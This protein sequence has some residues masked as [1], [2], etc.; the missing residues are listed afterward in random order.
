MSATTSQR[1]PLFFQLS[2][3]CLDI[4]QIGRPVSVHR[5]LCSLMD[6]EKVPSHSPLHHFIMPAALL[7]AACLAQGTRTEEQLTAMLETAWDRSLQV[8]GGACGN[9]GACGAGVGAGIFMSVFTDASPHSA[10]TWKWCN[11]I[12]GLC[13]QEIAKIPGPCCCK[14][15]CFLALQ[16]AVPYI[17]KTCKLCLPT[18]DSVACVYFAEN[19]ICKQQDCPFFPR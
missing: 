15:T 10:E 2:Q 1:H 14:R 8:P 12:T 3:L 9:L 16:A 5:A 4:F 18:E 17:E 19:E 6:C 13:L 11:E 7:T